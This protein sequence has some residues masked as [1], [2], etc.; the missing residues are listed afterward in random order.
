MEKSQLV[1]FIA[2]MME[3]SGFKIYKNFKTS[4]TVIDIYG[5]L[6]TLIGD[7]GVVVTCKNYDKQWDVEI[8]VLKSMEIESRRLKASKV[9]VVTS[10][11][12]SSQAINYATRKNIKLIDREDLIK[13]AKKFSEENKGTIASSDSS[14]LGN[15]ENINSNLEDNN[16]YDSQNTFFEEPKINSQFNR[17]RIELSKPL[18]NN[19]P[20]NKNRLNSIFSKNSKS[21]LKNAPRNSYFDSKEKKSGVNY[22]RILKVILNNMG[23]MIVI[24]V[25]LSYFIPQLLV[26][27]SLI[28]GKIAGV[29][30][31]LSSL[32]LSYGLVLALNKNKATW[33]IKGTITFFISV[34]ILIISI[35]IL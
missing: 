21:S 32:V 28:S 2:K 1:N 19:S 34:A 25:L 11:S 6:P 17:G 16:D 14:S 12:F 20:K 5:V 33:I 24:T 31:I 30:K 27:F 10:S 22:G 15:D 29:V 23:V 7:F 8:E 35:F 9:A 3:D 4:N 26:S 18:D 13:F